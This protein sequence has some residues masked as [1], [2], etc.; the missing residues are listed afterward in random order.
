VSTSPGGGLDVGKLSQYELET[1]WAAHD[2]S[3]VVAYRFGN[4]V[5]IKAGE[6]A[7]E[8]GRVVALISIEPSPTYVI[9]F[10]AGDSAE[11]LEPALERA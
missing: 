3:L 1:M 10:P 7:G 5:R 9:E 2:P 6:R 8:E 4:R 11:A